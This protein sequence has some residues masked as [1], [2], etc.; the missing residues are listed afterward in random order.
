M[1][2]VVDGS[3][4]VPEVYAFDPSA[5][6]DSDFVA[7]GFQHLVVGNRGRLLDVRRT[8]I[9]VVAVAA[10]RGQFTVRIDAFEDT[11]T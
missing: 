2:V 8:P 3:M 9:T 10:V 1:F 4:S 5:A 11:G 6:R 7:G